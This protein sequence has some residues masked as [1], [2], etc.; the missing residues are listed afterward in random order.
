[1]KL[2]NNCYH[3]EIS[4]FRSIISPF[5]EATHV[6]KYIE[7]LPAFSKVNVVV[8]EHIWVANVNKG[9][10]LEDKASAKMKANSVTEHYYPCLQF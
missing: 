7:H 9:Q 5:F 1:M 4:W 3:K 8:W 2:I 6:V 10:I